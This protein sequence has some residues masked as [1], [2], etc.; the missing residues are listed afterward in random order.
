MRRPGNVDGVVNSDSLTP[1][2][3]VKSPVRFVRARVRRLLEAGSPRY[4]RSTGRELVLSATR[5]ADAYDAISRGPFYVR[6]NSSVKS[7]SLDDDHATPLHRAPVT[8]RRS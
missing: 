7:I 3:G 1:G 5:Q 4:A 6:S 8:T 2:E